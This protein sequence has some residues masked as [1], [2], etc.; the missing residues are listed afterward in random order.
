M[1]LLRRAIV[2]EII[3]V[4]PN[5]CKLHSWTWKGSV[6]VLS[7]MADGAKHGGQ[8]PSLGEASI[9]RGSSPCQLSDLWT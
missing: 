1:V 9:E 3:S 7:A 4:I 6:D 2:A 5:G 8:L